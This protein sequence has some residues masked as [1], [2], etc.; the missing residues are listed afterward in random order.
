VKKLKLIGIGEK[1]REYTPERHEKKAGTPS[2]GGLLILLAILSSI[3]LW[4][5]F[6]VSYIVLIS[7][8]TFGYGVIGFFDDY[9]K[10]VRKSSRGLHVFFKLSTQLLVSTA[11]VLYIYFGPGR[12]EETTLLYVPFINRPV[13]D[14]S[15]F[16]IPFGILLL[17]STSNAVN[18]TDGLDGLAIGLIIFVIAA[19]AGLSYLSGHIQIANYLFIP[20]IPESDRISVPR[21]FDWHYISAYQK[22]DTFTRNWWRICCGGLLGHR[23]GNILSTV[24]KESVSHVAPS[25]SL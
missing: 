21:W 23:P 2:M 25:P 6:T 18:L 7:V 22:R 5:N 24:Q 10:F 9:L 12:I 17:I 4:G 11:V 13:I 20:F 8:A 1:V 15:Y 19:Y 14:L 16:Y 3:I